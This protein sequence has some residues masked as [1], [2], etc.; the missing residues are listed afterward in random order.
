MIFLP[1]IHHACEFGYKLS[2]LPND[3]EELVDLGK[4]KVTIEL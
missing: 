1:L 2:L 4:G 3:Y